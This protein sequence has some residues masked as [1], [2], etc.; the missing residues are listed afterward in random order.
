MTVKGIGTFLRKCLQII[1]I[2]KL[3]IMKNNGDIFQT[4]FLTTS[5]PSQSPQNNKNGTKNNIRESNFF[6]LIGD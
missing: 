6:I 5:A 1:P 4:S 2:N 3:A